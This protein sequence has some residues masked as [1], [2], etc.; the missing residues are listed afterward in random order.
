MSNGSFDL[1]S[2]VLYRMPD[3]ELVLREYAK[4]MRAAQRFESTLQALAILEIDVP[5]GELS[6][7]EVQQRMESFFSRRIGWIAQRLELNPPLAREIDV[8]RQARNELAHDYLV[9]WMWLSHDASSEPD[10]DIEDLLPEHLHAEA[11]LGAEALE[12]QNQTEARAAVAELGALC[13]RFQACVSTLTDRW[14]SGLGL[15][16]FST[17]QELEQSLEEEGWRRTDDA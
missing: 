11:R 5:A 8:L 1:F 17:W 6:S 9:R 14:F 12:E 16:E 2:G 7:D 13:E 4:T 10:S 15:R 3:V